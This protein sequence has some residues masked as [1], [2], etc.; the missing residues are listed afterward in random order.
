[1]LIFQLL[2]WIH[3][4]YWIFLT[5]FPKSVPCNFKE[6]LQKRDRAW[7]YPSSVSHKFI[8][9]CSKLP[10]YP[11]PHP[12]CLIYQGLL[13]R[14]S[15]KSKQTKACPRIREWPNC[16]VWEGPLKTFLSI[17][18]VKENHLEQVVQNLVLSLGVLCPALRPT[19]WE[20]QKHIGVESSGSHKDFPRSGTLLSELR[21]LRVFSLDKKSLWGEVGS[22]STT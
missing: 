1:M 8:F 7:R 20:G 21:Q 2:H 12:A 4:L 5:H 22:P 9:G 13:S 16:W 18:L 3:W 15:F 19:T 14:C 6:K 17:P 10:S 11:V